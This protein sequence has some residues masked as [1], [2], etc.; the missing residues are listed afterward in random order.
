VHLR[1]KEQARNQLEEEVK[2][3]DLEGEID[4]ER[5]INNKEEIG[6]IRV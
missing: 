1:L 2:E 5:G 6:R 4:R 3:I